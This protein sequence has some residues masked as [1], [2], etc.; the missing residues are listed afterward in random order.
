[1][2]RVKAKQSEDARDSNLSLLLD[3]DTPAIIE[4]NYFSRDS[5]KRADENLGS[6]QPTSY[7]LSNNLSIYVD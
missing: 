2:S 4:G 3:A 5:F 7:D 6:A 1:M